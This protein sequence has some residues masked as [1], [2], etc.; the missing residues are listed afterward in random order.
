VYGPALETDRDCIG[1]TLGNALISP[2]C[3]VYNGTSMYSSLYNNGS[4]I[5]SSPTSAS[6]SWAPNFPAVFP[7]G[8]GELY[9]GS[10]FA[11]FW[12]QTLFAGM[13]NELSEYSS[14]TC[15]G[16]NDCIFDATSQQ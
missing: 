3:A 6:S 10:D 11:A 2:A 7:V 12:H 15:V 16:A 1:A 4:Q 13:V 5:A 9:G 14:S 8:N